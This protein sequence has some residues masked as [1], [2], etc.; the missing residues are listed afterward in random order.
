MA[1]CAIFLGVL[2]ILLTYFIRKKDPKPIFGVYTRPGKWYYLK[3]VVFA[4]LYYFRKVSVLP[5][6]LSV[7]NITTFLYIC[8][9]IVVDAGRIK[10]FINTVRNKSCISSAHKKRLDSAN[11]S[12]VYKKLGALVARLICAMSTGERCTRECG[13]T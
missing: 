8:N 6:T 4:C 11:L 5:V 10:W 13:N 3:Y 7:L 12:F 2:L 9:Y 1:C